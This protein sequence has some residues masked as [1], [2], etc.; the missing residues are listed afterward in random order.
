M[1]A[2][3]HAEH[4]IRSIPDAATDEILDGAFAGWD[5]RVFIAP[6]GDDPF[7]GVDDEDLLHAHAGVMA[8]TVMAQANQ[9][10]VLDSAIVPDRDLARPTE[11]PTGKFNEFEVYTPTTPAERYSV[12]NEHGYEEVVVPSSKFY[13]GIAERHSAAQPAISLKLE[14]AEHDPYA[15]GLATATALLQM[16]IE[17]GQDVGPVAEILNKAWGLDAAFSPGTVVGLAGTHDY[18][19]LFAQDRNTNARR[20]ASW[21]ET[22]YVRS[23][24]LTMT[25]TDWGPQ[26]HCDF[27]RVRVAA[28]SM[29]ATAMAVETRAGGVRPTGKITYHVPST[30]LLSANPAYLFF[31]DAAPEVFAKQE[32]CPA[33]EALLARAEDVGVLRALWPSTEPEIADTWAATFATAGGLARA[34]VEFVPRSMS[35][36]PLFSAA[37]SKVAHV[38]RSF[39]RGM[40][41]TVMTSLSAR[42]ALIAE[43]A[44]DIQ[45]V[46][47]MARFA[48]VVEIMRLSTSKKERAKIARMA[49]RSLAGDVARDMERSMS[50]AHMKELRAALPPALSAGL[51]QRSS[52]IPVFA[53]LWEVGNPSTTVAHTV[54]R[55]LRRAFARAAQVA[56]SVTI[57][58]K[59]GWKASNAAEWL[60]PRLAVLREFW[61]VQFSALAQV[62]HCAAPLRADLRWWVD[63]SAIV[64]TFRAGVMRGFAVAQAHETPTGYAEGV[65]IRLKPY[66][67]A[68]H[69]KKA[70]EPYLAAALPRFEAGTLV[71]EWARELTTHTADYVGRQEANLPR[72]AKVGAASDHTSHYARGAS[73]LAT[74]G[75]LGDW[76]DS[77]IELVLDDCTALLKRRAEVVT[78]NPTASGVGQSM[79]MAAALEQ[80]AAGLSAEVARIHTGVKTADLYE[81]IEEE[82][83]EEEWDDFLEAAWDDTHPK[84]AAASRQLE[85]AKKCADS[86]I[87]A[88]I[89]RWIRA[90][91]A[92]ENPETLPTIM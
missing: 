58:E 38:K 65:A 14:D 74:E 67:A 1:F 50:T 24:Q 6:P 55:G 43:G 72:V 71:S 40:G 16:G 21:Q 61:A 51:A 18:A 44:V 48:A 28:E 81:T 39:A 35:A 90:E 37:T 64:N 33:A 25:T 27:R 53:V 5:A 87:A 73:L 8:A 49:W 76:V 52:K 17:A 26:L 56:T 85:A 68:A 57:R 15:I 13:P 2:E 89:V 11:G 19:G 34:P 23:G 20:L 45:T 47:W 77:T 92:E 7:E 36:A 54:L 30:S 46:G 91:F 4:N 88:G 70:L 82:V 12:I 31:T 83:P 62:A 22:S 69:M 79:G 41:R 60:E 86:T 32:R 66:H 29:F 78:R 3:V 9:M 42:F 10:R 80:A 75:A 63:V 84:H 59:V